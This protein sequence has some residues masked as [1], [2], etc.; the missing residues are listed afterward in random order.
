MSA[1]GALAAC[2]LLLGAPTFDP[3]P[4]WID[5]AKLF[6]SETTLS[7]LW[8]LAPPFAAWAQERMRECQEVYLVQYKP[9]DKL[10][11]SWKVTRDAPPQ[12]SPEAP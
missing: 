5:Q 4:A 11:F 1:A 9:N 6:E 3:P 8:A 10:I 12:P 7:A 2:T